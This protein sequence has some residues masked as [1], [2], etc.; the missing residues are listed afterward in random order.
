LVAVV[1][2]HTV[3]HEQVS[4]GIEQPAHGIPIR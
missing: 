4:M 2:V 1:V 3:E